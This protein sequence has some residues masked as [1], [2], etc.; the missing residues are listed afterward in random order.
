MAFCTKCGT[1]N[2]D[3]AAFCKSCG[4]PIPPV[5]PGE[6]PAKDAGDK[7]PMYPPGYDYDQRGRRPPRKRDFDKECEEECQQGSKENTWIWGLIIVLVGLFIIFEAGVKNIDGVP[8][9]VKDIQMWWIIPIL[10]GILIISFGI[11]LIARIDR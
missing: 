3:D 9:W 4:A 7:P 10:I 5:T 1:K 6:A 2:D 11:R 8:A